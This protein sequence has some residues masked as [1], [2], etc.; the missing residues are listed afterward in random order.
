MRNSADVSVASAPISVSRARAT[1]ASWL[2]G[3]THQQF[4][5][6]PL[7]SLFL[8]Q[9]QLHLPLRKLKSDSVLRRQSLRLRQHPLRAARIIQCQQN[10]RF[11]FRCLHIENAVWILVRKSAQQ[12]LGCCFV[13]CLWLACA[14][15]KSA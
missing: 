9:R 6:R 7:R 8:P 14:P 1:C 15:R 11:K 5:E 12:G 4:L 10:V 3:C 2:S 13:A